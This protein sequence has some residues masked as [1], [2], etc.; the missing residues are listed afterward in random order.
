[1]SNETM[2]KIDQS[3]K[4]RTLVPKL[5]FAEFQDTKAWVQKKLIDIADRSIKWSLIGGP[6]GSNLKSSDYVEKGV[7][8]IQ[9]QNIGDGEFLNDYK[10]FTTAAK[11][12]DLLS[13]N[14][15]AGEI[16]M[17]KMGDPVGRA[18]LIPSIYNR[19]VMC[20]DGIRLVVDETNNH[21]YFIYQQ[22]NS[23]F[24]RSVV[25][26]T[27]TGSTRKRIGLDELKNL[28]IWI[29]NKAEQHKVA[30]CLSSL[31]ELIAAQSR[32]VETLKLQKKGLI[33]QLFPR[34]G[35][36]KPRRRLLGCQTRKRWLKATIGEMFEVLMCKRIFAEETNSREGVPFFKIGT[37]GATPDAFISRKLFEDYKERYNYPKKGEILITCSGT[38]GKCLPYNGSDAYYQDSNIVWL[39]NKKGVIS[40]EFLLL[41]L[42]NVN[43]T[44]LNATTITRIYGPDLRAVTVRFPQNDN[45]Q[46][47]IVEF[48]DC[49]DTLVLA[50]SKKLK[51]LK[52]HKRGL[53]QQVF[54]ARKENDK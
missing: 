20:S 47:R 37:L 36:T 22:I 48:L 51:A 3:C 15:F 28:P 2:T 42:S 9:L 13:H 50:E 23:P 38:V 12:D 14:I 45:E 21:K 18:C 17:S 30:E 16:I 4:I 10:I 11:A 34:Q 43:W 54:P 5:R 33:Q 26:K 29:P 40:N 35:K 44:R 31:D 49:L 52:S 19:Y 1:M 6:F 7:R 27:A 25:E 32:K 39:G 53:M 46:S 41:L 24:F 8:I